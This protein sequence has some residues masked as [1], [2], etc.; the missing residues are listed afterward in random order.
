MDEPLDL[1]L[2]KALPKND[3]NSFLAKLSVVIRNNVALK[4]LK[5]IKT[6][7]NMLF[8]NYCQKIFDR[9]SLLKRHIRTHTG[10]KPNVRFNFL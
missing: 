2:P 3:L 8:C 10:E 6:Y 9:P 1:S 5:K 4:N 7:R